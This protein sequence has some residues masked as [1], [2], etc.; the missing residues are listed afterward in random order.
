VQPGLADAPI[1]K[2]TTLLSLTAGETGT[3]ALVMLE[4]A[5]TLGAH[6]EPGVSL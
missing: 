2:G 5:K 1:I 6:G 4:S 3:E